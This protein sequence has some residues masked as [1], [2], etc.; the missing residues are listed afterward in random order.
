MLLGDT[1]AG[2][3]NSNKLVL[4]TVANSEIHKYIGA[5]GFH[6]WHGCT[7]A[8]MQAWLLSAQKLN[9]PLM[10][11]EGGPNSALHRYP[12]QF[13]EKWFQ[14][15]EIDLYVRICRD[16][17]VAT[18]MEWQLTPNYSVLIGNGL[19]GDNGPLR[20]TQRFWNL[21][22]LGSTPEDSFWIPCSVDRPNISAAA[23][24]DI[25]NGLYTIHLVNNSATRK[26]TITN[27]PAAVK[28]LNVYKTDYTRGMQK[29]ESVP[30]KNG[31]AEVL[32]ESACYTTL[33]NAKF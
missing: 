3:V 24:A 33:T 27:I 17:Q 8:D 22:Q 18:I 32:L 26:A 29:A 25:L 30:V 6:T 23:T 1:G 21:K 9:L 10:A 20:P 4:P 12:N 15:S 31:S 2:T 7:T 28:S 19:Y 16:A 14:L 11:V 13:L 5:V